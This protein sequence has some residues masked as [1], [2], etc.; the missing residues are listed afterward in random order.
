MSLET[1]AGLG[2]RGS[3][4]VF[5]RVGNREPWTEFEQGE[6][7]SDGHYRKTMLAAVRNFS[8]G[9]RAGNRPAKRHSPSSWP[10]LV[11]V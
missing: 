5:R 9:T 8:G 11:V 7:D 10:E 4:A 1:K 3:S 6:R 2:Q